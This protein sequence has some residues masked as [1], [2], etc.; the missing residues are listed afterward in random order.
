M[1]YFCYS[2]HVDTT[3]NGEADVG[4][5]NG[6]L[7]LWWERLGAVLGGR[8]QERLEEGDR[9]VSSGSLTC[10]LSRHGFL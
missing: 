5:Q 2:V 9:K 6:C 3:R 7:L 10:L 4:R 1:A 8:W